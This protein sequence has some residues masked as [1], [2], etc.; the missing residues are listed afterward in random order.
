MKIF[1]HPLQLLKEQQVSL[2]LCARIL[3]V[4]VQREV[5]CL[6]AEFDDA[7]SP[8]PGESLRIIVMY[9]TGEEYELDTKLHYISTIMLRGGDEVYHVFEKT[10]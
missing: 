4:Q 7:P 10:E 6:W 8:W 5:P 2:R 1:K 9:A 3:T